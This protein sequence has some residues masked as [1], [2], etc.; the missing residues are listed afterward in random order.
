VIV[1]LGVLLDNFASRVPEMTYAVAMS[2]DG[3]VLATTSGVPERCRARL[4]SIGA[5][6]VSLLHGAATALNTGQ[7]VSNIVFMDDGFMFSMRLS[8]QALLLVVASTDCDVDQVGHELTQ[9]RNWTVQDPAITG[10]TR[11][12]RQPFSPTL[13]YEA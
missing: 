11:N 5:S 1:D 7:V 6:M 4:A 10:S 13:C 8:P 12:L 3:Q 2:A 9:L